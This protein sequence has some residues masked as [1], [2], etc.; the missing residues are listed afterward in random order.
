MYGKILTL[1]GLV[2]VLTTVGFSSPIRE[3][4]AAMSI[5]YSHMCSLLPDGAVQVEW[6]ESTGSQIIYTGIFI[7]TNDVFSVSHEVCFNP[8]YVGVKRQLQG[9]SGT[10]RGY[11]GVAAN[12]CYEM[13]SYRSSIEAGEWNSIVFEKDET[14]YFRLWVDDVQVL[15]NK[16]T[17]FLD[18]GEYKI[19]KLAN[20]Q[21]CYMKQGIVAMSLNGELVRYFIP[22]RLLESGQWVG[23]YYD[24]ISE[25]VFFN[26]GSGD[27]IIG[28]DKE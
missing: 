10:R 19:F 8:E 21:E 18:K 3:N 22:I 7:E 11:W 24:I 1:L 6:L 17:Y 28:P 14:D 15:R 4:T 25:S 2:S 23:C 20:Y 12:G 27:F 16:D 9:Y 5:D 26:S 13:G